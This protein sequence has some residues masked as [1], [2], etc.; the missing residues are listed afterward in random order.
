M[1][2]FSFW[3]KRYETKLNQFA[4]QSKRNETKVVPLKMGSKRNETI[5]RNISVISS[6]RTTLFSGRILACHAGGLGSIQGQ[7]NLYTILDSDFSST[8][9]DWTAFLDSAF[10]YLFCINFWNNRK[11]SGL[12][13]SK[14][15][16]FSGRILACH[17]GGPGSIPG[18]CNLCTIF[19]TDFSST[20][21]DW[22]AFLDHA[23]YY[24][25]V[26]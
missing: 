4:C 11:F 3:S 10:S 9:K 26:H 21:K 14:H 19:Y 1:T 15:W 6:F 13:A 5:F 8:P 12:V 7:W 24:H 16:W 22:I 18:Q 17:A 23:F 20:Q 2:A 25:F